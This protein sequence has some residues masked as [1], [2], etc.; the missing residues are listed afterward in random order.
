M[1]EHV[2]KITPYSRLKKPQKYGVFPFLLFTFKH[3]GKERAYI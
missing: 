3:V 1:Y 2:L